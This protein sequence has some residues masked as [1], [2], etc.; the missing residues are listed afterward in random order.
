LVFFFQALVAGCGARARCDRAPRLRRELKDQVSKAC[1]EQVFDTQVEVRSRPALV[2]SGSCRTSAGPCRSGCFVPPRAGPCGPQRGRPRGAAR[3]LRPAARAQAAKDFRVDA[4][5]HVACEADAKK[6]CADVNPGEGRVQDCLRD[7]AVRVSG[8]CQ[9]ELFRQE[10][11]NADDLRLSHRLFR[12]CN[13]DKNR[14]CPDVKYGAAAAPGAPR[15]PPP[16]CRAALLRPQPA[17]PGRAGRC[18]AAPPGATFNA[19][20]AC[21]AQP[22]WRAAC[23]RPGWTRSITSLAHLATTVCNPAIGLMLSWAAQ[24][25]R[26]NQ[27]ARRGRG[28]GRRCAGG[29]RVKDCLEEHREDSGFSAECRAEFEKMMEARAADFRLDPT[30]REARRPLGARRVGWRVGE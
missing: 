20:N 27:R 16:A 18:G 23:H 19:C 8:E 21:G 11:E 15:P 2:P 1:Q 26:A 4:D 25:G 14:F 17:W 6:L 13:G 5:L 3:R 28:G 24:A 7:K 9:E 12:K 30:L 10:V 22:R 29:A